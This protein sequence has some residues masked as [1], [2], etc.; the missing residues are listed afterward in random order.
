[1][2]SD[3]QGIAALQPAPGDIV[4]S[5][6]PSIKTRHVQHVATMN[7]TYLVE[8]ANG[9]YWERNCL[10]SVWVR[11]VRAHDA[12]IVGGPRHEELSDR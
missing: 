4:Q 1:M 9:G 10:P 11:W 12:M 6:H 3:G 7:V 8:A 5:K 2:K